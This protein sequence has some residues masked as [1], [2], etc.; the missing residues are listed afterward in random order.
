MASKAIQPRLKGVDMSDLTA[1]EQMFL[2]AMI[3]SESMNGTEACRKAGYSHPEKQ[4]WQLL[5]KPKIQKVL[6]KL[7]TM[8]WRTTLSDEDVMRQIEHWAF[9]DPIDLCDEDGKIVVDDMR[10]IPEETR[11]CINSFKVRR[12]YPPGEDAEPYDEIEIKLVPRQDAGKLVMMHRGMM[13]PVKHDVNVTHFDFDQLIRPL[14]PD[15]QVPVEKV[16]A[17][18]QGLPEPSKQDA[19]DESHD[20]DVRAT[21]DE[22]IEGDEDEYL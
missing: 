16:I 17:N 14:P 12:Y 6:S 3:G 9:H 7:L 4:A 10:K 18:P 15:E 20:E 5:Q 8:R 19:G 13:A 1:Q 2:M 22:L 21:I 11:K